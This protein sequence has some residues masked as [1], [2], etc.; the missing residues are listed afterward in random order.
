MYVARDRQPARREIIT[1]LAGEAGIEVERLPVQALDA[2]VGHRRHQGVAAEVS[3]FPFVALEAL[4]SDRDQPPFLLALDHI[5][6][7]QNFGA[8]ARTAQC[9]GATGIIITKDRSAP[10]S[11]AVSKASAGAI[12]HMK[13]ASITNMAATLQALKKEGI[14]IAGADRQGEVSLFEAD[15]GG[16]LALVIGGEEKGLRPLVKK[17][18]D[19]IVAIPQIG[20]IGSLNASAAAAVLLYEAFRQRQKRVRTFEG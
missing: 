4:L 7:P 20:P 16:A 6:D 15:L 19:F 11:P 1:T 2:Q 5:V 12:E 9:V 10:P 18:C 13:V 8:M 14:W 17:Q 3:A